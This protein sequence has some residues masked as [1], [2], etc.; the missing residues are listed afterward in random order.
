MHIGRIADNQ[1][2]AYIQWRLGKRS[3]GGQE[4]SEKNPQLQD[5]CKSCVVF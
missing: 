5:A 3:K 2:D 1:C 4:K